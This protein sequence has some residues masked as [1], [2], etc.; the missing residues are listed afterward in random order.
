MVIEVERMTPI[1][2]DTI[3]ALEHEGLTGKRYILL[4]GSSAGAEALVPEEGRRLARIPARSSS[5]EQLLEGA[6][7]TIESVNLLLAKAN[8][9]LNDTN[10]SNLA[11][12]L[13][14]IA[15][16]SQSL[17]D[18]SGT[19]ATVLDDTSATMANLRDA[20]AALQDMAVVLQGSAER[21]SGQAEITL[22]S[23]ESVAGNGPILRWSRCAATCGPSWAT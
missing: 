7:E 5:L 10:R 16:F 19:I 12:I 8:D 22:A 9:L 20:T 13:A 3:A 18:N 17:A 6:P 14:N 15:V 2:T 4:A 1:K 21:L 23:I 11:G